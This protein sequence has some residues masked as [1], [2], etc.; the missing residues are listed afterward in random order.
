MSEEED[1]GERKS[2][3]GGTLTVIF[4]DDALRGCFPMDHL[5]F[6]ARSLVHCREL[7]AMP[8][9]WELDDKDYVLH[10]YYAEMPV[11]LLCPTSR[12]IDSRKVYERAG[13]AKYFS[14]TAV[15]L[16]T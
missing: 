16:T 2:P 4:P 1:R 6:R 3:D 13:L 8:L 14:K 10:N 12:E 9:Y 5:H 11:L 15:C 7:L